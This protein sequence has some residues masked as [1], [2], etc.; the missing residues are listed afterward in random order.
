[1]FTWIEY[2]TL[3]YKIVNI[4]ALKLIKNTVIIHGVVKFTVKHITFSW[5]KCFTFENGMERWTALPSVI[6]SILLS[7]KFLETTI[8]P[9]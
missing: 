1:M 7:P 2:I 4:T 5:K 3:H 6:M 9:I 8:L